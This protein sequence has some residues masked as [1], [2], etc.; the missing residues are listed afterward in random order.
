[1]CVAEVPTSYR[2]CQHLSRAQNSLKVRE[3]LSSTVVPVNDDVMTSSTIRRKEV[4]WPIE[5][6]NIYRRWP[7]V[8]I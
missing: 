5:P 1:M 8:L 4:R 7:A 3:F 6:I 2:I